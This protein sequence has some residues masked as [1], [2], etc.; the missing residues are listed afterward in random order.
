MLNPFLSA[1]QQAIVVFLVCKSLVYWKRML[2]AFGCILVGLFLQYYLPWNFWIGIP[3]ILAGNLFLLVRGYD[4]RV[5]FDKYA[6]DAAWEQI[7]EGKLPEVDRLVKKMKKWD[8][9]ILDASNGL[10]GLIFIVLL[11]I[12]GGGLIW[13]TSESE[14]FFFIPSLDAA[15]LFLPHWFTGQRSIITKPKLLL[16]L[17]FIKKLLKKMDDRLKLKF[18]K[19]LLKKM[20]DR[21]QSHQVEYF[22][23]LK[24][25]DSKV[26]SDVKFRVKIGNQH[27]DFLG[28]YGQIVTNSVSGKRYPYFYVVLV[29]KKGY[30][31]QEAF[32]S[33]SPPGNIMKEYK[34]EED[35]EVLVIRQTTT[36]T[37][38]YHTS[39]GKMRRIFLE[40][41]K[42]AEKVAVES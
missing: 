40:G 15:I 4:N 17:K 2:L 21:L 34:V 19:K 30:G 16:K 35:V 7:D 33:Y 28:F 41:L 38:G 12:F 11:I 36:R 8:R 32:A 9:S 29:T 25:E 39:F 27:P 3:F 14:L 31:L 22:M 6:P 37:S 24:G 5:R 10:G 26:P 18:I 13:G 20:D 1:D 42:L 23:L